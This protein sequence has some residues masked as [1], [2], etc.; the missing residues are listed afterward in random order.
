MTTSLETI[1]NF[2]KKLDL[3]ITQTCDASWVNTHQPGYPLGYEIGTG[4]DQWE[5]D[6]LQDLMKGQTAVPIILVEMLDCLSGI[7]AGL[8][9]GSVLLCSRVMNC[10][11]RIYRKCVSLS[12]F[13]DA[14][15][16]D[17]ISRYLIIKLRNILEIISLQVEKYSAQTLVNQTTEEPVQLYNAYSS[18]LSELLKNLC[19]PSTVSHV[20]SLALERAL[21]ILAFDHISQ[22]NFSKDM[23]EV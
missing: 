1:E 10:V 20:S 2:T 4:V 11:A 21:R 9:L 6:E 22:F 19:C 23:Q 17:G 12:D 3:R 16:Q 18:L 7:L 5:R 13:N 15:T 8:Q 14:T